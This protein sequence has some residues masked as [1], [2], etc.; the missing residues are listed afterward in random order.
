MTR[1]AIIDYGA[2]N[3]LSLA[4]SLTLGGA[5]SIIVTQPEELSSCQGA[6]LPGVGA[7]GEAMQKLDKSGMSNALRNLATE[8]IPLLGICLGMQLFFDWLD[9]DNCPGL[10]LF[11]GKVHELPLK[12][13]IKIPHMG[14]NKVTWEAEAPALLSDLRAGFYAYF[15]HSYYCEP[16][17]HI[18][19]AC[20]WTD[21]GQ[22]FQS[23]VGLNNLWG[24]QFH[25]EKSGD[26]GLQIMR[27]FVAIVHQLQEKGVALL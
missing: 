4:R 12:P 17:A 9:E 8:Q 25:P 18:R 14:W 6:I 20:A 2:G 1:I 24:L 5:E 16:E 13:G 26:D 3:L 19:L 27:N 23:V 15:V 10:G 7:A 22:S 11:P 21:H